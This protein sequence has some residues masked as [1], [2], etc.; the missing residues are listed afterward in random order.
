MKRNIITI[1]AALIIAAC[2]NAPELPEGSQT[3]TVGDEEFVMVKINPGEFTMGG[4]MEQTDCDF[5]KEKPEH[6][7]ILTKAY[8]ISQTE[9][10][11]EQWMQLMPANPSMYKGQEGDKNLPVTNVTWYDCQAFVKA[12]SKKTGKKFRLP[13]EAE[14]EYAARG[15]GKGYG[16]PYAGS[17]FCDRVAVLNTNSN[18]VPHSVGQY[19]ANETG[20]YDM[21]GNVWEWVQDN[22]QQYKDS[23]YKDPCIVTADTLTHSIRGGSFTDPHSKCRTSTREEAGPDYKQTN[24]GFRVVMEE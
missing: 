24:L 21:S 11:Q 18:G 4:T 2:N 7:V 10:T 22:Y 19:G 23:V 1:A 8:Y 20:I 9:V 13:T 14:W 6:K 5:F 15:A 12:L 16:L 3:V 17:K